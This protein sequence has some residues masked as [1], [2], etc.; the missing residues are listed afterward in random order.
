MSAS[1]PS[2]SAS[3]RH[4]TAFSRA[5]WLTLALLTAVPAG[6]TSASWPPWHQEKRPPPRYPE[7]L[8]SPGWLAAHRR[9]ARLTLVDARHAA[10]VAAGHIAGAVAFDAA[11]ALPD[12]ADL[13]ARFAAA[14]IPS[15]GIALCYGDSLDRGAAGRLFWLLEIA[16][17]REVRVL[18][19]GIEAWRA[20]GGGIE[21]GA[22]AARP[23]R[24]DARPDTAKLADYRY[25]RRV[26]GTRGHT[27]VDWRSPRRWD[28]G[29]VPH[30]LPFPLEKLV[31]P[32]GT[33]L[34]APAM[35][36]AFESFGP[37]E[38][39]YVGL[40]DEFVVFGDALP[41]EV[42]IDP[43]LAARVVGI[44]R[45]RCYPEGFAGWKSHAEASVVR[46]VNAEE[47]RK[48][49][50]LSL[51]QRLRKIPPRGVML[52]DLRGDREFEWGHVPGAILLPSWNFEH[53][54]DSI[55]TRRWPDADRA[56]TPL[57]VYCY[58]VTCVRS[59]NCS[60]I[61]ARHGFR[62]LWWFR[63]GLPGWQALGLDL[64][65]GK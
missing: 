5:A 18:N 35:R 33:W 22:P 32:G 4:R 10:R 31:G 54:L 29:H 21:R 16:G 48:H 40:D 65:K 7:I 19:G 42:S 51:W 55:V 12:P 63:D 50:G 2:S 30:S 57:I 38:R 41:G 46:I 39:D 24:F 36:L 56:K 9:D 28:T 60:S 8:V 27:L 6:R 20:R 64:E 45:V 1:R 53:D 62:N 44:E 58:G 17:H 49:L 43:Y 61:A 11:A 59:R 37:R 13:G 25:V 26:F 14:G 15:S 3:S 52:F 34:E 23:A 47:V